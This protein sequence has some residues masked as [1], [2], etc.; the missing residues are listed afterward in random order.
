MEAIY[1]ELW[2]FFELNSVTTLKT[3]PFTVAAEKM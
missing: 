2:A 3:L 1:R